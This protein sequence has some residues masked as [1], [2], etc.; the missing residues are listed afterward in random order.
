MR[1]NREASLWVPRP[2]YDWLGGV[3]STSQL[4][5]YSSLCSRT[6]ANGSSTRVF[7]ACSAE[8]LHAY[9]WANAAQ[10]EFLH[11]E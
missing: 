7:R 10:G 5:Q 11:N 2:M 3:T 8:H 6:C 1:P 9:F 4:A